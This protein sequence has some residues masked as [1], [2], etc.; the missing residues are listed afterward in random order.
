MNQQKAGSWTPW[1]SGFHSQP[2]D[3]APPNTDPTMVFLTRVEVSRLLEIETAAHAA[4]R[5]MSAAPVRNK[6]FSDAAEALDIV[7]HRPVFGG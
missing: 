5:E 1:E 3:T 2:R 6:S 7:L 4:L